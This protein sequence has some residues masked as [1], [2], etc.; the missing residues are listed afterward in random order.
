MRLIEGM[1]ERGSR[2]S[3]SEGAGEGAADENAEKYRA[4][5]QKRKKI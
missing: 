3:T 4:R 2:L 1:E 5:H